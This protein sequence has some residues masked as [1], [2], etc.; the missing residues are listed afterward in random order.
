MR[1]AAKKMGRTGSMVVEFPND[2][3]ELTISEELS[4]IESE[5]YKSG[6][7]G[8]NDEYGDELKQNSAAHEGSEESDDGMGKVS[9]KQQRLV[10]PLFK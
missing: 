5:E 10:G 3:S 6:K 2:S 9:E 4:S 1:G 7:N 8:T